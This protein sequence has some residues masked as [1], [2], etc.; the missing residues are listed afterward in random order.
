[1]RDVVKS[2]VPIPLS[3]VWLSVILV[4]GAAGVA[5]QGAFPTADNALFEYCGRAIARGQVLYRDVW[6]DKLPGIYYVNALW[7]VLFGDRYALH[8]VAETFVALTSAGLLVL[9]MRDFALGMRAAAAAIL[10]LFLSVVFPLNTTEAYALPLLLAAILAAHRNSAF[11]AGALV[12]TATLFWIP[13]LL[14]MLPLSILLRPNRALRVL[15]MSACAILIPVAVV[16]SIAGPAHVPALMRTWL[17]YASAPP[18]ARVHHRIP[19]LNR[20]AEVWQVLENLWGGAVASGVAPLGVIL[21]AIL[22]KPTTQAQKFGVVFAAAM[23]AGAFVGTRFYSHYFI[24]CLAAI[25]L[26]ISAYM[27]RAR[28]TA[29]RAALVV[30]GV[31]LLTQTVALRLADNSRDRSAVAAR[32]ANSARPV[33]AGRLTLRVDAYR[34]ELYLALDPLLR[35]P[36]EIVGRSQNRAF[37]SQA[38]MSFPADITVATVSTRQQGSRVCVRTAAPWRMYVKRALAQGFAKCL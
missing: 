22:R 34:P 9:V 31:L 32:L 8:A 14:A 20:F 12:G 30:A 25:I 21:L 5:I 1:M 10:T 17:A 4:C 27:P 16:V 35:S 6:D 13:S 33:V 7:Q 2:R 36:F 3:P 23:L 28:L 37:G 11:V 18:A 29:P 26:C 15:I 24:P 38:G 19:F